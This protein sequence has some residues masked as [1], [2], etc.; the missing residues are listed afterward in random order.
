MFNSHQKYWN[1]Y[2]EAM[3]DDPQGTTLFINRE[4]EKALKSYGKNDEIH[5][6]SICNEPLVKDSISY[7]EGFHIDNCI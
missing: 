7:D 2:N 5:Y 1:D 3:S 4:R 6:C